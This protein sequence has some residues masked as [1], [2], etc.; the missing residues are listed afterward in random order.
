M[1]TLDIV[2]LVFSLLVSASIGIY[3]GIRGL[4]ATPKEYMLGGQAMHPLP[5]ALSMTVGTV[6]AITIMANAGEMYAYGTQLWM[7]DLGIAIGLII[8]AKVFIPIF[9]PMQMVSLYQASKIFFIF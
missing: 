7:M 6:S 9:Y 8:V 5:L 2:L 4:K 1:D 3:H